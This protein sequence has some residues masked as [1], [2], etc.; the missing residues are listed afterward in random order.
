MNP[1]RRVAS[2]AV[3]MAAGFLGVLLC[4]AE[5]A[6]ADCSTLSHPVYVAGSSAVKPF[7]AKVAAELAGLST[8]IS[9]VYQ[10]Q[11]SCAG[12]NYMVGSS[13]G[14]ITGTGIIWDASGAEVAGGCTLGLTG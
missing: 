5:A 3:P 14:T 13:P 8:P 6:A 10:S 1:K 9:L 7:L 12:V 2:C 4:V 11:G